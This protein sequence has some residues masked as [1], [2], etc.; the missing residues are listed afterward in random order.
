MITVDIKDPV[1][2]DFD[3][4]NE[5]LNNDQ[6]KVFDVLIDY[7]NIISNRIKDVNESDLKLVLKSFNG[8]CIF[9]PRF[10]KMVLFDYSVTRSFD[11]IIMV[12]LEFDK[13]ISE[14]LDK[15]KI[16]K[17]V[18]GY[19]SEEL[20]KVRPSILDVFYKQGRDGLYL[21]NNMKNSWIEN[22]K[23]SEFL[24]LYNNPNK[25]NLMFNNELV[26]DMESL[27]KEVKKIDHNNRKNF[28]VTP[29]DVLNYDNLL[30]KIFYSLLFNDKFNSQVVLDIKTFWSISKLTVNHS[31]SYNKTI[32]K[33]D[34][35]QTMINNINE[36]N[37]T[38]YLKYASN[39]S[40]LTPSTICLEQ[41]KSIKKFLDNNKLSL[42]KDKIISPIGSR[43]SIPDVYFLNW[44]IQ[45]IFYYN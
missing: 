28:L 25:L 34:K 5:S 9:L 35:L 2:K 7:L 41:D 18:L 27:Y 19:I 45:I 14:S 3:L 21:I 22:S 33:Y 12:N 40:R 16:I 13:I 29:I 17:L 6:N 31:F 42:K 30:N 1:S 39:Y 4:I 26:N 43:S 20:E 24:G 15:D 8:N 38:E 36:D 37:Y 32:D 11:P 10:N 23:R 44:L